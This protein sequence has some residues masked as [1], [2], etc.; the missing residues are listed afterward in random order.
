MSNAS[1]FIIE[2]GQLKKYV[3]PGG[4]VVIPEG[5]RYLSILA[6]N[7]VSLTSLVLPASLHEKPSFMPAQEKL[8]D[9]FVAEGSPYFKSV[10]GVLYTADLLKLVLCPEG[11][12]G[13]LHVP[14]GV[15]EIIDDAMPGCRLST[16]FLPATIEKVPEYSPVSLTSI[17]VDEEN[18][19][20]KSVD[21]ILYDAKA[22]TIL[23]YPAGREGTFYVPNGVKCVLLDSFANARSQQYQL[24]ISAD[25]SIKV[26]WAT[27]VE[28]NTHITIYAPIGSNAERMARRCDCIF[29][30]EGE[31]VSKDDSDERKAR[32]FQEWRNIFMFSTKAKG[33]HISKYVRGA[34]VVYL[35]DQLGKSEVVAISKTAF[36]PDVTVLC[37]PKLFAKL[38]EENRN[39]TIRSYL[40][41]R[42]LFT[43]EEQTCLL[44]YLKKH[45]AKY[46]VMFILEED[47]PALEACFAV[48]PKVRTLMEEC[49]LITEQYGKQ[50]INLFLMQLN[51]K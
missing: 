32:S 4:D 12:T 10:D 34:K 25:V 37:S 43:E 31:P 5:V 39:T 9:I 35:P 20:Y 22:E 45:R 17:I 30:P 44:T 51:K 8:K 13:E 33:L 49:F 48:M 6:F 42:K 50:H 38:S 36:P 21:G 19:N 14:Y 26:Q 29:F 15:T 18:P 46:L 2:N 23:C 16:L 47:Y 28:G 41:N 40:V 24:H 7:Q 3:G 11:R 1:D 27:L